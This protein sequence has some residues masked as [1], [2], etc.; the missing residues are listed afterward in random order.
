MPW[1]F[2]PIIED[3]VWVQP[4]ELL[5]DGAIID[6][7]DGDLAIDMGDRENDSSVIEQGFRIFEV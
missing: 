3:I 6:F 4:P 2:D 1:K 7:E 5:K